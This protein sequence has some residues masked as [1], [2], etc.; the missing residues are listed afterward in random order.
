MEKPTDYQL[1]AL[2]YFQ[3]P[4]KPNIS[5]EKASN[6][7]YELWQ[8]VSER[9]KD[10]FHH[11]LHITEP[12]TDADKEFLAYF[13]V[14][15]HPALTHVDA[16]SLKDKINANPDN[17]KRWRGRGPATTK[18]KEILTFFNI[19]ASKGPFYNNKYLSEFE[20]REIRDTL[21]SDPA[22][23]KR[24]NKHVK[25]LKEK[26]KLAVTDEQK[27]VLNFFGKPIPDTMTTPEAEELIVSLLIVTKNQQ[28]WDNYQEKTEQKELEK[29]K[30]LE[31]KQ[32]FDS[33]FEEVNGDPELYESKKINK[34]KFKDILGQL[35]NS[36]FTHE[37]LEDDLDIFY[38][39]AFELYPELERE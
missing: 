38:D 11:H 32:L 28:R 33:L 23:K 24:W 10:K 13:N 31:E 27:S 4:H 30:R 2:E 9:Q 37:Q 25:V 14:R 3:V 8:T 34:K 19:D 6:L 21:L 39:K 29:K 12:A 26:A 17:K 18:Q 36:G 7:L 15:F 16:V 22:N 1:K 20:A 5:M 35:L